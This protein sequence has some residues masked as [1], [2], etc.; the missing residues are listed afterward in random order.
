MKNEHINEYV[1]LFDS[2]NCKN[3]NKILAG[4]KDVDDCED[5]LQTKAK[6]LSDYK[7]HKLDF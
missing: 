5:K 7:K 1:Y 3:I 6:K 4:R 2:I